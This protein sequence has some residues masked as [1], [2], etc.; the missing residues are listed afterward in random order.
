MAPTETP[1]TNIAP[2]ISTMVSISV[3]LRNGALSFSENMDGIVVGYGVATVV[4]AAIELI[5]SSST[6]LTVGLDVG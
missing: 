6:M 4:E 3:I 2:A 5:G 1:H